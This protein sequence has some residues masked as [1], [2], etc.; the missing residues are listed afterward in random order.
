MVLGPARGACWP[1]ARSHRPLPRAAR[2][3]DGGATAPRSRTSR[4]TSRYARQ[5]ACRCDASHIARTSPIYRSARGWRGRVCRLRHPQSRAGALLHVLR[6]RPGAPPA[7]SCGTD[8]PPGR[9]VLHRVRHRPG[10]PGTTTAVR[11]PPPPSPA[12][13]VRPDLAPPGGRRGPARGTPQGDRPLRRPLGLHRGRRADGSREVKSMV[14]RALQRLGQEVDRYGGRVDKYI[15]DNVMA[16]F[17]APV[18]A[19][20]RPRARRARRPRDAARDGRDQRRHRRRRRRLVPAAGGD[21]LRRGPR[22]SGR[23]A[24]TP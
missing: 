14:D 4:S 20:G 13:P 5:P 16:V 12:G 2:R 17:G 21:Q 3:P 8:N 22:G 15:G 6:S 10:G 24:T 9:E 11:R 23:R 19:R 18:V 1:C 7:P